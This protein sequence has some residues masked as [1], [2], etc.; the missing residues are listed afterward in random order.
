MT[1]DEQIAELDK[2][3]A[4]EK[5]ELVRKGAKR[6]SAEY[7]ALLAER[8]AFQGYRST[9]GGGIEMALS[10]RL[11]P[12]VSSTEVVDWADWFKRKE[13]TKRVKT[14]STF[15]SAGGAASVL[16]T[17]DAPTALRPGGY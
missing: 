2:R 15:A 10:A 17:N 9:K 1:I 3:L 13:S 16:S 14:S 4:K 7:T 8:D 6:F 12:P 11:S 5:M